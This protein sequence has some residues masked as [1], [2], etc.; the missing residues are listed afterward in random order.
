[1][2][3][4][5]RVATTKGHIRSARLRIADRARLAILGGF[6]L[7]LPLLSW[8]PGTNVAGGDGHVIYAYVRSLLIDGDLHLEN[9]YSHRWPVAGLYGRLREAG[10][11]AIIHAVDPDQPAYKDP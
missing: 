4:P 5:H 8:G 2:H 3:H 6:L 10:T 11:D 1:M 7:T 9:E